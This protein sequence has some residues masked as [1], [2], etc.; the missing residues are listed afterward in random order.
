MR[1]FR[2]AGERVASAR[3]RASAGCDAAISAD[4]PFVL[5]NVLRDTGP[6]RE[7]FPV[8]LRPDRSFRRGEQTRPSLTSINF[9]GAKLWSVGAG[10]TR[11]HAQKRIQGMNQSQTAK[12][13]THGEAG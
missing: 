4:R 13:M 9:P 8:K 7:R 11:S 3:A 5:L 6:R 10:S 12:S 2:G 1:A